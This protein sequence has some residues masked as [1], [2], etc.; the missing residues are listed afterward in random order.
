MD[1]HVPQ[2]ITDQLRSRS[3]SSST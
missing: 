3:V 2:A 1:V